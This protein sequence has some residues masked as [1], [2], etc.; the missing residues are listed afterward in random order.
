MPGKGN[1]AFESW[2]IGVTMSIMALMTFPQPPATD[3]PA[4]P[5]RLRRYRGQHD[6]TQHQAAA[7]LGVSAGTWIA[8]ENSQRRPSKMAQV[9]LKKFLG[10]CS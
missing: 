5:D 2:R 10:K 4:W 8:W 7:R 9:V 3:K 6:L 1:R